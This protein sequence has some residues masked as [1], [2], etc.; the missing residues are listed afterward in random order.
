MP[1]PVGIS[2][3]FDYIVPW[4]VGPTRVFISNACR[5]VQPFCIGPM[6]TV[7]WSVPI[8]CNGPPL[9]IFPSLG[10][11]T[12][13]YN[14]WFLWPTRVSTLHPKRHLDWFSSFCRAHERDQQTDRT[15]A[16]RQTD[17]HTT[18]LRV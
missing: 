7:E 4:A 1:I 15:A 14:A 12:P 10:I 11:C 18:L 17:R 13:I 9:N 6:V 5:S 8:R 2:T 3:P 16:D